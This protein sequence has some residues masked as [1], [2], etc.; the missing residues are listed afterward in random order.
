MTTAR[1]RKTGIRELGFLG[2]IVQHHMWLPAMV[3]LPISLIYD[4]FE[5]IRV[6]I[7]FVV[8]NGKKKHVE[9]VAY[10]QSQVKTST[11]TKKPRRLLH[12]LVRHVYHLVVCSKS[13]K[14]R[15]L[16]C[17]SSIWKKKC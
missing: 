12:F 9:K 10:V 16:L 5:Y 11:I 8:G 17:N 6:K 7:A 15:G 1:R 14:I 2:Y 4:F 13:I 3:I